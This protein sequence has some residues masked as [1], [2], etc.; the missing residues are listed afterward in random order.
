M[1]GLVLGM[2]LDTVLRTGFW[3][4]DLAWQED[5]APIALTTALC[6]AGGILLALDLRGSAPGPSAAM[7]G[8]VFAVGPY[9][10]LQVLFLQS[11]AFVA[12]QSGA[13]IG[14]AHV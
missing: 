7:S 8:T 2:S 1:L 11:P 4:W 14:R 6:G 10:M 5:L 13:Q 12:S 9:L 3:T